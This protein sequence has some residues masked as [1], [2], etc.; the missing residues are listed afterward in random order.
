MQK[1]KLSDLILNF[2]QSEMGKNKGG[3]VNKTYIPAKQ[4]T[5]PLGKKVIVPPI[6]DTQNKVDYKKEYEQLIYK[7]LYKKTRP[8]PKDVL[9]PEDFFKLLSKQQELAGGPP[10]SEKDIEELMRGVE[11][12][13]YE[14]ES[15]VNQPRGLQKR[16]PGPSSYLSSSSKGRS[17]IAPT[18]ASG[19]FIMP[20]K[21]ERGSDLPGYE[22]IYP[23]LYSE[24]IE[25]LRGFNPETSKYYNK[26]TRNYP[27]EENI[28][29]YYRAPEE[30]IT[31]EQSPH[32]YDNEELQFEYETNIGNLPD[33]G[34]PQKEFLP[35]GNIE[36]VL[37]R[38][39]DPYE[40]SVPEKIEQFETLSMTS[41][42]GAKH[43]RGK[44]PGSAI[45]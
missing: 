45:G 41:A 20:W 5:T 2:S 37:F 9:E 19:S 31:Y 42:P 13:E 21:G 44:A 15:S 34:R 23:R 43:S 26:F 32:D 30:I 22:N 35:T 39:Y 16:R 3:F 7:D 11:E 1:K 12:Y 36:E 29:G 10:L 14:S 33:L 24:N 18:V 25:V 28:V 38:A 17:T 6:T 40:Q 4:L 27:P 8:H